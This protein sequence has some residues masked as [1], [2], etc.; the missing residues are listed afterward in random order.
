[1]VALNVDE[2]LQAELNNA[3]SDVVIPGLFLTSAI[4]CLNSYK[5]FNCRLNFPMCDPQSGKTFPICTQDCDDAHTFCGLD[6]IGCTD[7]FSF[8]SVGEN[9]NSCI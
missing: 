8:P 9:D 4:K 5:K 1:M 7:G 6:P 2:R 3:S